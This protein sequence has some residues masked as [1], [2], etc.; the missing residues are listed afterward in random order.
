[1]ASI[2]S[3]S[4]DGLTSGIDTKSIIEDL[5]KV[6]SKPLRRL[7]GRQSNL[8]E[9]S[10]TFNTMKTNLLELKD[11]AF[12][13]KDTSTLNVYSAS[14]SDEEALSLNVSTSAVAGNYSIKILS[15]AQAETLSGDSFEETGTDLGLS[16]EILING[17][18]FKV[19][20]SDS[21]IDIR[22]AINSLDIGVKASILK[23]SDSDNRLIISSEQRGTEGFHIANVG[24]ND[25][26]GS[27]GITDGTKHVREIQNGKVL[28][29]K[30]GSSGSTI[31]SLTGLSSEASGNVKIRNKS[32]FIDLS[33]DTLSSIRDKIN[34]LNIS[35]VIATVESVEVDDETMYRLAITGTQDFTDEHNVLDSLGI[36]AGGTSGTNA[37]FETSTLYVVDDEGTV[38]ENTKLSKLGAIID[39]I[40]ETITISGTNIDGSEVARIIEIEHD[41]KINNV[42]EGIE[43]AFSGNVT[44]SIEDGKINIRSNVL[45]AIP[46]DVEI[47]AN[48]ESGGSLDFGTI[49]T[50]VRGR[51]RLIVEGSN[52]RILVNNIEVIRDT[53]EID[54]VLS[55]LSLTLKKADPETAI[56]I[57]VDQDHSAVFKKI[58][59]FVESYNEL[60]K[61]VNKNSE[62]DTEE[63]K[64]G[65]LLGE[66][67]TRTTVTRIQNVLQGTVYDGDMAF[68]QLAQIG[69]ELTA[70]GLFKLNSTKLNDAMNSDIDSVISLFTISRSSSDNDITFVYNS[71]KTKPGT[72]DVSI[73]RAAEKAEVV[74]NHFEDDVGNSGTITVTD[75]Y[76]Y[77]M[78]VNYSEDMGV[79][80]IANIINEEARE[81]HAEI[82]ESSL[83]LYQSGGETP[84]NQNTAIGDIDGVSVE[85]N[86]TITITGTNRLGKTFQRLITLG[87]GD[88]HTIQDILDSIEDINN[89]EVD[90]TTD[91][92]G[93][94]VI[95][96]KTSGPSK[97]GLTIETTVGG[98][99]FGEFVTI[100]KGRNKI[101]I[102][103]AVTDDNRL[104]INHSDYGSGKT[105]TIS[106]ASVLGISDNEYKGIDVAGTINGVE[107]TGNGQVLT[108]SSSDE[109]AR[110]ILI[111]AS[112]T[113]EELEIE[114]PEQGNVTLISGVADRLYGELSS[115]THSIDGFI[116]VK[117]DSLELEIGSIDERID[118][119]NQ[120]LEQRREMYVRRFTEMEMALAR[121]QALQQTLSTSLSSLPQNSLFA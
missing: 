95:Q 59:G 4:F 82:Q 1:M 90:A 67:T 35:G 48:N 120:R 32:F 69:I 30:F 107:G 102:N 79:E 61:F 7:E 121:L 14:S 26:L 10:S 92:E 50:V 36:L 76:G 45:G 78:S 119:A 81:T 111:K 93:H 2:G 73:T 3:I 85:E 34:D 28:S 97:I 62:Y 57:T 44:A 91:S 54:D 118:I 31:G 84:I 55:G 23:V 72:Y 77:S 53:N 106:G 5:L 65:P 104:K 83:A 71:P 117:I 25:I 89:K 70:E 39:D 115:L 99:D 46:L 24:S 96:D 66:M 100:Q 63:N 29:I 64:A 43:E 40:T 98:L 41:T 112:I 42:L 49:T 94:I 15:L 21:L 88:S 74:S 86:D 109:S 33:T 18:N 116:Q 22:N 108:A 58:E 51:D 80:D 47:T 52:A 110:G 19:R 16:G 68:N 6:D 114:G 11:K 13:L 12:E 60:I 75:N 101:N 20:T 37:E 17:K 8:N 105:F 38:Q 27:L 103:A 9:I 113:P 56:N 87:D